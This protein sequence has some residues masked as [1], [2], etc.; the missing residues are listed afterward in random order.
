MRRPPAR[1][2]L[3]CALVLA[4]AFWPTGEARST[5]VEALEPEDLVA[6][7]EAIVWGDVVAVRADWDER[8]T[9]IYTHV[10]VAPRE[11]LKGG[12]APTVALKLPGGEVDGVVSVVHGV[13]R[14]RPG[15]EVVLHVTAAHARSG[16]RVPVGLGQ[17]LH[18]VVR[19]GHG[20]AIATR[21]TRDLHLARPGVAGVQPGARDAR[22]LDDLLQAIRGEV[23][24]QATGGPR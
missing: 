22:P 7:A 4:L 13:P 2:A 23:A 5:T 12:P 6:R 19:P 1:R 3:G 11:T 16:V 15:E 24:R 10:E 18:R 20:P 21:D 14:F 17:G 9:R 8:R